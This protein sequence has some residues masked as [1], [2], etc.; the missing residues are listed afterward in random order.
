MGASHVTLGCSDLDAA[1]AS[2]GNYGYRPE[3][4]ERNVVNNPSKQAILTSDC[5][6]H[7]IGLLRSEEGFPIELVSYQSSMPDS[8]GRYVGIFDTAVASSAQNVDLGQF[9]SGLPSHI[10]SMWISGTLGNLGAPALFVKNAQAPAGLRQ[11]LL[12]V[13]DLQRALRLWRDVLGFR[14][15]KETGEL[16]ELQ[17]VSPIAAWRL[18]IVLVAAPEPKDR[19]GLDAR[20]M[21]CLS[22]LS[23]HIEQDVR[24]VVLGG[25][26]LATDVFSIV[27]NDR[28]MKVAILS[29]PDG[30][31]IELLQV[32]RS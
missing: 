17:F 5:A 22:M 20:G 4:I 16:A 25:A 19:A 32:V 30:A 18:G 29:D 14:V 27:I 31:F 26:T 12:P 2:L 23:S 7:G 6:F 11:L 24:S 1:V 10:V 28:A 3:F 9:L 8:F 15:V 13:S 21:A